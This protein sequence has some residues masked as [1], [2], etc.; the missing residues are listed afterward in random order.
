MHLI[1]FLCL[2]ATLVIAPDSQ[3]AAPGSLIKGAGSSVYYLDADNKRYVFPTEATYKTWYA[4]FSTVQTINDSELMTYPLGGNVTYRP[5]IRLIKA[6]TDPKVYAVGRAGLLR[7]IE[8]EEVA[9]ALY[10]DSWTR[11]IDDLPDAFFINYRVGN[12]IRVVGDFSPNAER[13]AV[14]YIGGNRESNPPPSTTGMNPAPTSTT[15]APTPPTPSHRLVLESSPAAPRLGASI[16][17]RAE[18]QPV[19]ANL[20][21]LYFENALQRSCDYYICSMTLDLPLTAPRGNFVIRAEARYPSGEVASST[22]TITPQMGSPYLSLNIPRPEIEPASQREIIAT[23]SSAFIAR[24]L[25]IYLDGGVV[26]GCVSQQ[27]CRYSDAEASPIGTTHSVYAVATDANGQTTRS[28]T[29]TISVV[30][31]DRPVIGIAVGKNLIFRGEQVDVTVNAADDDGIREINLSVDGNVVKTCQASSC[32]TNIGPWTNART[33]AVVA[34]AKDLL[35]AISHA[36]ST[37]ITVE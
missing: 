35:G 1:F 28:D 36:T 6:T 21:K 13:E 18:A 24:Y 27:E 31:N 26:R 11:M 3:A 17:V 34:T 32:T 33:V 8:T 16:T 14:T 23:V 9:R 37:T 15:S 22:L 7:W 25:D 2:L 12:S 30:A 5:G 19:Q 20:V 29:R 4:D 10:G